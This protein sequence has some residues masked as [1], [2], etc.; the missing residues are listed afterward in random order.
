MRGYAGAGPG[1]RGGR[2]KARIK[3]ARPGCSRAPWKNNMGLNERRR[4]SIRYTP[5]TRF[6]YIV[7]MR[8]AR[9]EAEI[10]AQ[11][12]TELSRGWRLFCEGV[13][14]GRLGKN[15]VVLRMWWF[16]TLEDRL[17]LGVVRSLVLCT[18][19]RCC[20]TM[21]RY[22]GYK[23]WLIKIIMFNYLSARKKKFHRSNFR[24]SICRTIIS[25]QLVLVFARNM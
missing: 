21:V 3:R 2:N 18:V 19:N 20:K 10:C 1:R 17:I 6:L 5:T 15:E 4:A 7:L 22:F 16:E 13:F 23:E 9:R 24:D 12:E 11:W 8:T 14:S 25:A